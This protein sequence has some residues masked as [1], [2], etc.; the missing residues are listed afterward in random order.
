[1]KPMIYL[2]AVAAL[3]LP[4]V[5]PAQQK[6]PQTDVEYCSELRDLYYRYVGGSE[7]GGRYASNRSDPE[8]RVAIAKCN[9]GDTATGIP[10]LERKLTGSKVNLPARN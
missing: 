7:F 10:V 3:C 9:A 2:A 6:L 8:A 4:S 5:A 1:M